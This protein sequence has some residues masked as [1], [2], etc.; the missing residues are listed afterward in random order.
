MKGKVM[1]VV[2][3]SLD[4]ARRVT[5]VRICSHCPRRTQGTDRLLSD[6]PRAC[7]LGC[8]LFDHL[9]H[10]KRLADLADPMLCSRQAVL[11]RYL[12]EACA[13]RGADTCDATALPS[14]RQREELVVLLDELQGG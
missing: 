10:L 3:P 11:R 12:D 2:T 13:G 6:E 8:P 5:R 9:P 1:N 14:K 4:L 7:E